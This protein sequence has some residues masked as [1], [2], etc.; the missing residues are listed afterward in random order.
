MLSKAMQRLI[1]DKTLRTEL[2]NNAQKIYSAN[3][4]AQAFN[5]RFITLLEKVAGKRGASC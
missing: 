1:T 3:F 5:H 2:G 4:T